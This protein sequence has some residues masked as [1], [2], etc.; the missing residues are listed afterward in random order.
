M[1]LTA[2]WNMTPQN[3]AVAIKLAAVIMGE[4]P[5]ITY[6]RALELGRQRVEEMEARRDH[7]GWRR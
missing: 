2:A 6:D 7:L 3:V 5:S 1:Q 4:Q